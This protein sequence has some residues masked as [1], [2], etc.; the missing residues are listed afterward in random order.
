M[1]TEMKKTKNSSHTWSP[2][3]LSGQPAS[4][5]ARVT[6]GPDEQ[7][8]PRPSAGPSGGGLYEAWVISRL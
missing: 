2:E 5:P 4:P 3:M 1:T 8:G 7:V 6:G